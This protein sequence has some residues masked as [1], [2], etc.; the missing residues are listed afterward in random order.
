MDNLEK[1]T[2]R[3]FQKNGFEVAGTL[4]G[5]FRHP[6]FGLTDALVMYKCL[7]QKLSDRSSEVQQN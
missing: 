7:D 6:K 5:A 2:I 3:N 4:P 1:V